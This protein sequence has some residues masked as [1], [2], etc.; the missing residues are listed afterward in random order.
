MTRPRDFLGQEL[1][2][3]DRVIYPVLSGRSTQMTLATIISMEVVTGA[4][5]Y[6]ERAQYSNRDLVNWVETGTLDRW[7]YPELVQSGTRKPTQEEIDQH[8]ELSHMSAGTIRKAKVMPTGVSS[9][10]RQHYTG[11]DGS[12]QKAVTLTA[13]AMSM[14]K[15]PV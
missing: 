5:E 7:G 15:S 2:I 6:V 3:G 1:A 13:N 11:R 8:I 10:W 4:D 12:D 9:R 14:V